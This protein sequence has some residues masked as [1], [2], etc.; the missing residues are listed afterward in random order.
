LRN[1]KCAVINDGTLEEL[2][3]VLKLAFPKDDF[4]A[5]GK[6]KYYYADSTNIEKWDYE[7]MSI[8]KPTQ[9]VKDF[10]KDSMNDELD[11]NFK[12]N[13]KSK[14]IKAKI[15]SVDDTHLMEESNSSID[16]HIVNRPTEISRRDY[17]AAMALQGLLARI[18]HDSMAYHA[19]LAIEAADALIKELNKSKP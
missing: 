19:E 9:S 1:G 4:K 11:V 2:R 8:Y 15:I 18:D 7:I 12:P 5:L 6:G 14:T 16:F 3:E 13:F 17:F 10:L